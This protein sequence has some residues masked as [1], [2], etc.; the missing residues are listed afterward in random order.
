MHTLYAHFK[1]TK[2]CQ[3]GKINNPNN[4]NAI[5]RRNNE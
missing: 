2:V 5:H 4:R 3:A 1:L